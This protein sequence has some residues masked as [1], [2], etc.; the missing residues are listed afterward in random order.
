M[1]TLLSG[2][3]LLGVFAFFCALGLFL[4]YLMLLVAV[5]TIVMVHGRVYF[6]DRHP[7]MGKTVI[8]FP[9]LLTILA[10]AMLLT[11]GLRVL[12][13]RH[14]EITVAPWM[15]L[16]FLLAAVYFSQ[17][18]RRIGP[19]LVH[20]YCSGA[21]YVDQIRASVRALPGVWKGAARASNW[22]RSHWIGL[23]AALAAFV[24]G[25]PIAIGVLLV[26]AVAGTFFAIL[27][28][29]VLAVPMLALRLV[30]SAR[31]HEGASVACPNCKRIH[32]LPG[33]G[34]W[35]LRKVRCVC[36][37]TLDLWVAGQLPGKRIPFI[38]WYERE[39]NPGAQSLLAFSL[40]GAVW[41]LAVLA[42]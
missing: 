29:A 26:S 6:M 36:G 16:P 41:V 38:V 18:L 24:F 40:A 27:W 21:V 9:V 12:L 20:P 13:V 7:G 15:V 5:V 32:V 33:P 2:G 10:T 28:G 25:M 1:L 23:L 34:P 4:F 31:R 37:G 22:G 19:G 42:Q 17:G 8:Y 39:R 35:G 3:F 11:P 30:F 14:V